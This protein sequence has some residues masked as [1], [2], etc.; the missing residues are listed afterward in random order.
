MSYSNQAKEAFYSCNYAK[1]IDIYEEAISKQPELA[2]I[3]RFNLNLVRRRLSVSPRGVQESSPRRSDTLVIESSAASIKASAPV[4]LEDLYREVADAVRCLPAVDRANSPL[5]SVLMTAHNVAG[6]IEQAVTSVLRQTWLRLEL[7]VVDDASNDETWAILQRLA[8]SEANLRCLRLN[9]NLGTYFAKNYALTFAQ[10]DFIF[11]QD[12][13][14]LSHP[15]RIRLGMH[16]LN[17]P[18]VVCVR[19]AYSRVRFPSG[20]VIPVNGLVKKLGLITLGVRRS[21]FDDIG[22][23]NC[24]SKA[25]DDEF[26]QRLKAWIAE[27]GGKIRDLKVPL[28]FNT[29]RDGSLFADM[30]AND[31]AAEGNI[32]QLPSPSRA[33]YVKAFSC[34]HKEL[35][36]DDFK[37]FFRFPVLRDLIPVAP[38]MT[39]LPN[40]ALPIVAALCSIPER[41]ELLRQT[42]ES[43]APQVDA[44]HVYLDRYDTIPDFV[45]MCHP[46]VKVVLSRDVPGLGDTSK[47]LPFSSLSEGCYYLTADDN[48]QYPPDYVASI[49]RRI[50]QY[51]RQVVIGVH[52]VLVPDQPEGYSSDYRKVLSL[53][54]GLERD[55]LVNNLGTGTV[56]FYSGLLQGLDLSHFHKPGMTDLFLSV[57]CKDR[58]IPM[59]AIARPENWLQE[60]ALPPERSHRVFHQSDTEQAML[61][62]ENRPWG[63]EAIHRAVE[64]ACAREKDVKIWQ[65]LRDLVPDLH[66]CLR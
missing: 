19:G 11:F 61:I 30:I 45:R 7:I 59:V 55:A 31:P 62:R 48:V 33:S 20:Q 4:M 16:E 41:A 53:K 3:Y 32:V 46:Q 26:F 52:G 24:T 44:V 40:P 38:D 28:Y 63:Y 5:V 12:G 34:K 21:V 25:S 1:A 27:K 14:D 6:Y 23:F 66:A 60:I 51:D 36:K 35:L 49:I 13:D 10:G 65:R 9:T 8:K 56:G 39:Y 37:R 42:L 54:N 57:Y 17:Q 29:L 2:H 43:L 50:E 64:G 58:L 47:F 22:F 18:G 15:D